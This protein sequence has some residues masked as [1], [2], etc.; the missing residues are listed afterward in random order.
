MTSLKY[1]L[2]WPNCTLYC[3]TSQCIVCIAHY[4]CLYCILYRAF[5]HDVT[6]AMLVFQ[7]K[8]ILIRFF[9]L[10]HQHGRHGFWWV[11]PNLVPR[12]FSLILK[13]TLG[14]RMSWSLGNKCERSI[15]CIVTASPCIA[16]CIAIIVCIVQ[17]CQVSSAHLNRT[18][19]DFTK[20]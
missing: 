5:A 11:C 6:A 19:A 8:I 20:F 13:K 14:T 17:P 3:D 10:E 4:C 7:F 1:F 12:L 18:L 2:L 16:P 15:A 9:C